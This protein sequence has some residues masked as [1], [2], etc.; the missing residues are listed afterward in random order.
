MDKQPD[1]EPDTRPPEYDENGV[2]VSLIRWMLT[3]TPLERLQLL[4]SNVNAI[5]RVREYLERK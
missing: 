2:D 1:P 5:L 4:Q 3:L